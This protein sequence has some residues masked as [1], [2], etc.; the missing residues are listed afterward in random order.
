MWSCEVADLRFSFEGG[1][2]QTRS[3]IL[4]ANPGF[5]CEF[6]GGPG[7]FMWVLETDPRFSCESPNR[8]MPLVMQVYGT[9]EKS[10]TCVLVRGLWCANTHREHV[11]QTGPSEFLI[12]NI[13]RSNV[14]S[15]AV[16]Y[17]HTNSLKKT[18]K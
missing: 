15:R 4:R 17:E 6:G 9:P 13:S 7:I 8:W 5:S 1:W 3:W 14:L 2:T 16:E 12:K 10:G 11:I 18:K